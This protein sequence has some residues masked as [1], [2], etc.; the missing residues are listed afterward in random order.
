MLSFWN[1][2]FVHIGFRFTHVIHCKDCASSLRVA[3]YVHH[4]LLDGPSIARLLIEDYLL[5]LVCHTMPGRVYE[6]KASTLV[7]VAVLEEFINEIKFHCWVFVQ[8]KYVLGE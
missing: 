2:L 5:L 1:K 3:N 6:Q 8:N 7:L 4:A